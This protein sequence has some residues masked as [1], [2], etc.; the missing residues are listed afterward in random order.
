ML[1]LKTL[2]FPSLRHAAIDEDDADTVTINST[3]GKTLNNQVGNG[4]IANGKPGGETNC[5]KL[6]F[7]FV[8]SIV[9]NQ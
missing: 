6:I 8:Y 7:L 5:N 4:S 9:D 2:L 3:N 1:K